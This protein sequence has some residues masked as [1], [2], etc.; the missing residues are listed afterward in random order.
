[1]DSLL[2]TTD[3]NHF[4]LLQY[5]PETKEVLTRVTGDA[6]VCRN[7]Y[8]ALERNQFTCQSQ[9]R[10]GRANSAGQL[11]AVDQA[12]RCFAIYAYEGLLKV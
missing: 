9:S 8:I 2:V 10:M 1:M 6:S 7:E 12:G 11:L 4:A 3:T 5:N